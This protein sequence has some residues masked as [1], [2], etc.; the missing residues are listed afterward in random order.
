MPKIPFPSRLHWGLFLA[1]ICLSSCTPQWLFQPK[2]LGY[3]GPETILVEPYEHILQPSDKI[4]LSVWGHDELGV[5]SAF[6]V[7][8]STLEQGK[9]ISIDARGEITLPLI[10]EVKISE[11]S[12]REA[13]LYLTSLFSKYL[14]D[15]IVYLR[16]LS[17]EVTII[18]EIYTP[19][20]YQ[21]DKE[22]FSLIEL[23]GEAGGFTDYADRSKIRI[24]R[25]HPDGSLEELYFDLTD[26]DVLFVRDLSLRSRDVIYI[27]ERRAK[28]FEQT[29]SGKIVPIV[30]AIGSVALIMSIVNSINGG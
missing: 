27:P 5:G 28:Q 12:A 16:I 2:E 7:F 1:L 21:L 4:I 26:R 30:G 8:S 17:L 25:T 19:A 6:S 15:P 10:G 14:K 13:D 11:L 24:L 20:N 18:G 9:Y 3:T 29:V 22:P 23:I